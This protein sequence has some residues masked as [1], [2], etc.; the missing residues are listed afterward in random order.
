MRVRCWGSQHDGREQGWND[1]GAAQAAGLLAARRLRRLRRLA[2]LQAEQDGSTVG[3]TETEQQPEAA[4]V[5]VNK[6]KKPRT[7]RPPMKDQLTPWHCAACTEEMGFYQ[8]KMVQ[9]LLNPHEANGKLICGSLWWG[10]ARCHK[11]VYR[12]REFGEKR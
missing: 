6:A 8:H 3:G 10:C 5:V 1:R 7:K 9:V 12:I 11:P 2:R 4:P